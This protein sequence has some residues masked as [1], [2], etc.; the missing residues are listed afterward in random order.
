MAAKPGTTATANWRTS[1]RYG[2]KAVPVGYRRARSVPGVH[3]SGTISALQGHYAG[4]TR[5]T[6]LASVF[7][8]T[9]QI[10]TLLKFAK[11]T[12]SPGL[13]AALVEKAADLKDRADDMPPPD[14]SPLAPDVDPR[15]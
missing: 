9:R 2:S 1:K 10:A 15:A 4:P 14:S 6:T 8:V 7:Y 3:F 5:G 12:K 13:A 11:D